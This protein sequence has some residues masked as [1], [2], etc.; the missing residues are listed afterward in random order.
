MSHGRQSWAVGTRHIFVDASHVT[1]SVHFTILSGVTA[2]FFN[3]FSR[4]IAV[5]RHVSSFF[6]LVNKL[7]P[8]HKYSSLKACLN[9]N[10]DA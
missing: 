4:I 7:L 8:H 2:V 6:K 3:L 10:T 9:A 1:A 5:S